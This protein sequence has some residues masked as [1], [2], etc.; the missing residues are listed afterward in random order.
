MGFSIVENASGHQRSR[1]IVFKG[2]QPNSELIDKYKHPFPFFPLAPN[3]DIP[4][5]HLSA[6]DMIEMS[7]EPHDDMIPNLGECSHTLRPDVLLFG[8]TH[9]NSGRNKTCSAN[10]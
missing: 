7:T 2:P 10:Y 6:C 5:G 4:M 9:V 1:F 3:M 8:A